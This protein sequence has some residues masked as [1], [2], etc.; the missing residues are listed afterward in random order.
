MQPLELS[1]DEIL[2]RQ[3]NLADVDAIFSLIDSN[4]EHLSQNWD[5]T[6]VK[7]L[8]RDSVLESIA[9][10]RNPSKI[11]IGIWVKSNFAGSVNLHPDEKGKIAEIGCYLGAQFQGKGYATRA[12]IRLARYGFEILGLEQ[13]FAK[14][15]KNNDSSNAVVRKLGFILSDEYNKEFYF[16]IKE[17]Q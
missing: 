17:K 12:I 14:V 2:L 10:P 5:D 4:R 11:R 3:F 8:T 16:W 9:N 1:I 7:Y 13:I 6:A 15:N